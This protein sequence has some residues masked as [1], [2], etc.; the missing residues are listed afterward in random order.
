MND[1]VKRFYLFIVRLCRLLARK[2]LGWG[3]VLIMVD[4]YWSDERHI[5]F[6]GWV[7]LP[8]GGDIEAVQVR[9]G[10]Q[11]VGPEAMT[12]RPDL[13]G[14]S[15][16]AMA[17]QLAHEKPVDLHFRIKRKGKWLHRRYR[18]A[19]AEGEQLSVPDG[20]SLF[21][22]FIDEVNRRN[23]HVLEI[24]SRIVSPG[25]VS[26]RSLFPG[27]ASY[28]GFDYYPDENTDIVG[29]AHQLSSLLQERRFDAVFSIAVFEHL[30]M[31]W[32]VAQ[33]IGAILKMGGLTYHGTVFAWP[34]HERPW[35]FW[36]MSDDALR[37]LFSPVMG[38][39][40]IGAGMFDPVS[41]HF[42]DLRKGYAGFPS[43]AAYASSAILAKK[44]RETEKEKNQWLS[45]LTDIIGDQ[46][47]YPEKHT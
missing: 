2:V 12:D 9:N 32:V 21:Q 17:F 15:G 47:H 40:V 25:S 10:K 13:P 8:H 31:P 38:F 18:T 34:T 14:G 1:I 7:T 22:Q 46:S 36:R 20:G 33:E 43:A 11:W 39:E 35:D 41:M 4:R 16:Q 3:E 27:A 29:D 28:T 6:E 30:A 37:V 19:P 23:L 5:G 45:N 42:R 24:G 26:K 44:V